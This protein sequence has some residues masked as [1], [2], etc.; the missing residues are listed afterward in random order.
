[1]DSNKGQHETEQSFCVALD[2]YDMTLGKFCVERC[3]SVCTLILPQ[4]TVNSWYSFKL[5]HFKKRFSGRRAPWI[6]ASIQW[7]GKTKW[8]CN[9]RRCEHISRADSI[10]PY[11]GRWPSA[12]IFYFESVTHPFASIQTDGFF[13]VLSSVSFVVCLLDDWLHV[14]FLFCLH[15]FSCCLFVS[16]YCAYK[17]HLNSSSDGS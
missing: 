16:R 10:V 9:A 6:Y 5:L 11:T 4:L 8:H 2:T 12:T 7:S 13:F 15:S 3:Q 17:H 1:M 14:Q